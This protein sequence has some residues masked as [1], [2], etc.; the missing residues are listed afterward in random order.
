MS[1]LS[2][3]KVISRSVLS[4]PATR[5]Y[6]F[7]KRPFFKAT[8]G[9]VAIEIEKCILCGICQKRCPT[10]AI[11]VTKA[12]GDWQ[13]NRLRCISCGACVDACPKKCLRLENAYSPAV[14]QKGADDKF[15]QPSKPGMGETQA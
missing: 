15:H 5:L 7:E 10:D 4:R 8:R 13:I 9:A 14:V 1:P 3:A 2:F 12:A 6:P 11:I